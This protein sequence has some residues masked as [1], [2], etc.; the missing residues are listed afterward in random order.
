MAIKPAGRL[1]SW[2]PRHSILGQV[3]H[4]LFE[5]RK[6]LAGRMSWIGLGILVAFVFIALFAPF[7]SPFDPDRIR[8]EKDIPPWTVV[9]VD[10]NKT[11]T[12]WTG[13][14][15]AIAAAQS[16]NDIGAVSDQENQTEGFR[17]FSL[18]VHRDAVVSVELLLRLVPAGT[19]PG[20]F[21]QVNVSVDG[22]TTWSP[23]FDVRDAGPI[24]RLDLMNLTA[25][26]SSDLSTTSFQVGVRH[27]SDAGTQ[28]NLTLDYLG[29][30]VVWLSHWHI[31]GTDPVGRDVFSRVLHGTRTSLA[32]MVIGVFVAVAVGFP[33]GLYSGY[34]G[35]N[36]DKVLVLVMDSLYSFPGLLF[37][38][39]I[40][41]LLGK[42]VVNIG[43]AVTV[44]YIPLY[45]R[46]TRSQVLS[47]REELYVEA[48]RAIGAPPRRI[49]LR[50]IALN[51]LVAIPVI[52]S[53]SAADTIL[54]AAGLSFL[55]LGV[56]AD[57]PDWGRDLSA[58]SG[59]IDNGIWWSSFFPGLV[60]VIL[61]IGL[62][63]LGEGLNDII[64]PLFKK[65]RA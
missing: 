29:V 37:A 12:A 61:T 26:S 56:E 7:L 3:V 1:E 65:E 28:G 43:L 60:I 34:T 55:G 44:I 17:A 32:I 53:L 40:A 58:A 47:A 52:F 23:Y 21:L 38:G 33:M 45:F 22:G 6:T 10:Q 64:N 49:M 14:W 20:H 8:D 5:E 57:I 25:W 13:N 31:M 35:G 18:R 24:V 36:V 54:T 59:V 63:F 41:V 51:V 50:Y 4:P 19:D 15:T 42:G 2:L 39:L 48:A 9:A 16:V 30:R 11:F 46:V 62:S 27:A